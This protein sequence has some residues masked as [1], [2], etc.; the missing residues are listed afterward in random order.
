MK[1]L[2]RLSIISNNGSERIF[3]DGEELTYVTAYKVE[4]SFR[5][6]A[7][8][9]VTVYVTVDPIRSEEHTSELQSQR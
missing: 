6:V 4:K 2:K 5:S 8:L 1:E 3:L 9:T 7:R